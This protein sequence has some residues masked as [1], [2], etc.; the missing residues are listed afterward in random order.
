[1]KCTLK[2]IALGAVVM[3]IGL[4]PVFGV[5]TGSAHDF[6]ATWSDGEICAPCHTPHGGDASVTV[7]PLWAHTE[8]ST[9]TYTLYTSATS[10]LDATMAQPAGLSKLCLSCHDGTVALSSFTGA[11]NS[12]TNK[13]GDLYASANFGIDLSNDHPFG[14]TYDDALATT[15]TELNPPSTT[16]S[17]LGAEIDDD[18]LF[19]DK[20]ECASCHDVHNKVDNGKLLRISNAGSALCLTCHKK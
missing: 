11:D 7:A 14:F 1:M 20:I 12:D 17:G 10:T 18:M 15:D 3:A 16:S 5:I 2:L 13:M 9:A 19:S 6:S 4:A 8:T